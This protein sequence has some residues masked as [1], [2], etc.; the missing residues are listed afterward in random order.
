MTSG[1]PPGSV[2]VPLYCT[3]RNPNRE[4][5]G[6]KIARVS[7][8]MGSPFI[9]WQRMA[10]DIIGEIDPHTGAPWYRE[11][12]LIVP[13]QAGKTVFVRAKLTHR[14]L[15]TPMARVVYTCQTRIMAKQRLELDQ[16]EPLRKSPLRR[17]LAPP[18]R[19]QDPRKPGWNGSTGDEHIRFRNGARWRIDAT[20]ESSGHGPTL[21]E[22][23][24]D[25]AFAHGDARVEAAMRPAMVTVPDAQLLV[26]SAAGNSA[27]TYLWEKVEAGRALVESGV[28]SR[29]AYI[30]FS[31]PLTADPDDP[32]TL[33]GTHPGVNAYVLRD[34]KPGVLIEAATILADRDGM[35]I[36]EWR[37]AYLGWWP[38]AVKLDRII[39]ADAWKR[40]EV[41]DP[42]SELWDGTPV[43]AVDTS[44]DGEWSSVGM[45]AESVEPGRI[46]AEVVK[47]EPGM[48]WVVDY[49][50]K[51]RAEFGG[52]TVVIDGSGRAG[53]LE[54]DFIDREYDVLRLG[55]RQKVDAC[56][57][58]HTDVLSGRFAHL[59]D[60]DLDDA[61][62][63]AAKRNVTD[64]GDVWI[65][66]KSLR[67]ITP[68]YA[69]TLARF[70]MAER[71]GDNYDIA[72]S[73][74]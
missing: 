32:A 34:G 41:T 69:I 6:P 67:D 33:L 7:A 42:A 59:P 55:L 60:P 73:L 47:T 68:L 43:W 10:A 62:M 29:V 1:R 52:N 50:D 22:G 3:P 17:F 36:D 14:C 19:G 53:G 18:S 49:V 8:D 56:T 12:R 39:P 11:A 70:V 16:Y 35:D 28:E 26:T 27:S 54:Q 20:T 64:G 61:V 66:G 23:V 15:T 71:M 4:T 57:G 25:E 74:G 40:T 5:L 72:D 31:A 63:S 44:P 58:L 30:E 38:L 21:H 45:A 13:R 2:A 65:R 37:R 24:V 51:C 48:G 46:Y 9:E